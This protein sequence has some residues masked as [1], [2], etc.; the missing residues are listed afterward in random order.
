MEQTGGFDLIID[1][2]MGETLADLIKVIK[3]GGRIVF[4]GATKGNP[5][6]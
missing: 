5:P 1:S 4:Y 6:S 3:P 2:A